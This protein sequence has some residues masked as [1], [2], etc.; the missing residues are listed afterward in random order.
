MWRALDQRLPG[1]GE[2]QHEGV[3]GEHV[4]QAIHAVLV[5]QHETDQHHAPG[6]HMC[7]IKSE[8]LH[9]RLRVTNMSRVASRASMRAAPRNSGTRKTRILA[10]A[11]SK[12]AS[13][14][15]PA[16]SLPA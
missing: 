4:K 1:D 15:P 13:R 8:I 10:I 5:K 6:Q 9:H 12:S 7:D 14:K 2:R 16:A 11:V 3:Q